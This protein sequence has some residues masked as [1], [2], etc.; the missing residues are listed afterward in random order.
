MTKLVLGKGLGALIPADEETSGDQLHR[1][2]ALDQIAPN[3]MQPRQEF[4]PQ[5][6]AELADS[7]KQNGLM[8]PLVV[9]KSE[10]GF[11]IIAGERR[12]RAARLAGLTSV[13][14]TV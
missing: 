3:P 13:P 7:L 1:T 12:Y 4:D 5:A 2:V 14:V 6:M 10:S 8:Q 11:S 9:R